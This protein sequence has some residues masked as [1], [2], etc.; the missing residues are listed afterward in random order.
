MG[1][2]A[3]LP[4]LQTFDSAHRLPL[5]LRIEAQCELSQKL[6]DFSVLFP[7]ES[8]RSAKGSTALSVKQTNACSILTADASPTRPC[9]VRLRALAVWHVRLIEFHA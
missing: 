7:C 3:M 4:R 1:R 8:S 2:N 6:P 5:S 9:L